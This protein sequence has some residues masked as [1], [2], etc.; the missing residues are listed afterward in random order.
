MIRKSARRSAFEDL[1]YLRD[2]VTL[3]LDQESCVGCGACID[4]CPREVL[5]LENRKSRVVDRDRCMECGAC[6]T[7]CATGAITVSSGVGCAAAVINSKL[8]RSGRGCCT[9]EPSQ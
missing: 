1:V 6:A 7:N 5:I 9:I 3:K 4:V 8:G 2:V